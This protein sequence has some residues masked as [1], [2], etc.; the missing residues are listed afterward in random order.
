MVWELAQAAVQG[1]RT[2]GLGTALTVGGLS[3]VA[4]VSF[5]ASHFV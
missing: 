3:C 4:A 2:P 1:Q 5:E